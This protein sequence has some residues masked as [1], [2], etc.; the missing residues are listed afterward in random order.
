MK[1]SEAVPVCNRYDL[2]FFA[3]FER[4]GWQIHC[5][6]GQIDVWTNGDAVCPFK[7][8][9]GMIDRLEWGGLIERIFPRHAAVLDYTWAVKS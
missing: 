8:T 6:C 1:T 3:W 4:N 9:R 2:A 7:V 5:H